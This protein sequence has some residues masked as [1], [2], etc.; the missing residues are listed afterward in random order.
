MNNQTPFD[1][2]SN[3]AHSANNKDPQAGLAR[4]LQQVLATPASA[5]DIPSLSRDDEQNDVV[6]SP[7]YH[8]HFYQQLPNF[9]QALL[10]QE[11]HAVLQYAP[12]VFHL[13]G[14]SA[15]HS[16]YL[17]LYDSLRY[18]Y[19]PQETRLLVGQGARSLSGLPP[20][21][22]VNFCQLLISQ[23]EA[24]L[25]ERH[26]EHEDATELARSLLLQAMQSS[27]QMAQP[28]MRSRA[29]KDLVR[30]ATLFDNTTTHFSQGEQG[31]E[32]SLQPAGNSGGV[33]HPR[34]VRKV[35]TSTRSQVTPKGG[36]AIYLQSQT[37]QGKIIQREQ[38]LVLQLQ[39]LDTELRG[40]PLWISIPLGSLIEPVRWQGGNP[41]LIQSVGPVGI[42]GALETP[43]GSTELL[44]ANH[45][46]RNLLEAMFL[47]LKIRSVQE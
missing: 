5:P 44:L 33:R 45:E 3:S 37:L 41:H 32:Y 20:R 29:L 12:L 42:D 16:A 23:A 11:P 22:V 1:D 15:C 21:M 9:I 10:N 25:R 34:T 19:Q 27:A 36:P 43:L 8:P 30:V 38:Q 46:D 39:D 28:G 2:T 40:R 24:V 13:I 4:W 7:D 47:L 14:C 6:L 26:H 18:A 35:E 31:R 17:E